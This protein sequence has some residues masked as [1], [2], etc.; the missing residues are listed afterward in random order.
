MLKIGVTGQ[1]GFVG[2]H[3]FN[4]VGLYP[5][6]FTRI[7]FERYFFDKPDLLDDFVIQCDVI[8]HL[9]GLNRHEDLDVLYKTNIGLTE[10]LLT[11]LQRT[12]SKAHVL[13]S[14]ST[15]EEKDNLYGKSKKQSRLL[16]NDWASKSEGKFTGL[17]IPNV[18]GPFGNPF[19]NSV[20]ATFC[21]QLTH[22]E[23]PSI[24]IDEELKLIYVDELINVFMKCIRDNASDSCYKVSPTYRIKVSEMLLI[25]QRFKDAYFDNGKIPDLSNRFLL[26]L[27]NTYR[28]FLDIAKRY[29][30]HLEQH[31]DNRGSFA[32]IIRVGSG[33]NGQTSFST[34]LPGVTRGNHFHTRKIERFAI[35]KGNA[36]IQ[37]RKVGSEEVFNLYLSGDD[38]SY[39]DMPVWYAHNIKNIGNEELYTIFWISEFFDSTDSDTYFETV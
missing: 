20:V 38:L 17:I 14:S 21:Y 25:L 6:E 23:T 4:S 37:L 36:L 39:V 29:P 9:A 1:N 3:A 10:I 33:V 26:N 18:F 34:T 19:Y 27:F 5:E 32:E 15:Q 7:N 16:L 28:S 24:N 35:I 22:G 8:I 31:T 12:K 2:M 11:S 30:V 13:F